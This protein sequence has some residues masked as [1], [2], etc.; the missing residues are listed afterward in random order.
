MTTEQITE[1]IDNLQTALN[2]R[3]SQI[4]AQDAVCITIRDH[5]ATLNEILKDKQQPRSYEVGSGEEIPTKE[6]A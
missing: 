3:A 4:V 6:G 5:I 2:Q 1:K